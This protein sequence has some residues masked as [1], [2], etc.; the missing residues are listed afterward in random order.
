MECKCC[1]NCSVELDNGSGV[2]EK[3]F[4]GCFTGRLSVRITELLSCFKIARRKDKQVESQGLASIA[5]DLNVTQTGK[6]NIRKK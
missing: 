2:T 5:R 4:Y 1:K 6:K 3:K